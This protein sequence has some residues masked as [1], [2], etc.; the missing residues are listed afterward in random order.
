MHYLDFEKEKLIKVFQNIII[1]LFG[2]NLE[3]IS[4]DCGHTNEP[5]RDLKQ[6]PPT[7]SSDNK[8][9]EYTLT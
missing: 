3:I 6:A 4:T 1:M 5:S 9:V 8:L 7:C 2:E